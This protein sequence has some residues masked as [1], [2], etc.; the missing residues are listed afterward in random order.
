MQLNWVVTF[1]LLLFTSPTSALD[2]RWVVRYPSYNRLAW[3]IETISSVPCSGVWNSGVWNPDRPALSDSLYQL[4][5]PGRGLWYTF[6]TICFAVSAMTACKVVCRVHSCWLPFCLHSV[7]MF[8]AS[9]VLF[10]RLHVLWRTRFCEHLCMW[11][12]SDG[13]AC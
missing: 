1:F 8:W 9:V 12:G 10:H 2:G 4:N 6:N 11:Q 3:R 5:Y 13:G 7:D